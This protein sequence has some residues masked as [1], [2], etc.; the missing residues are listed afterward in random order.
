MKVKH[1]SLRES[2]VLPLDPWNKGQAVSYSTF[3]TGQKDTPEGMGLEEQGEKIVVTHNGTPIA[4][5]PL[6]N[7]R[8]YV[9]DNSPDEPVIDTTVVEST[10]IEPPAETPRKRRG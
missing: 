6:G 4:A 2:V 8:G 3:R 5:I 10:E 9:Y 1:A 7:I